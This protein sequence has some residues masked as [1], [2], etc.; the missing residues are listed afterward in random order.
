MSL[1]IAIYYGATQT[2]TTIA[3]AGIDRH[4]PTV[5]H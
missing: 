1:L 2:K 3:Y 4:S 5:E